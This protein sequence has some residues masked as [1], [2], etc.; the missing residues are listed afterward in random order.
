M[1]QGPMIQYKLDGDGNGVDGF[2]NCYDFFFDLENLVPL[3]T[4]Q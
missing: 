3:G 4:R 1:V 2:A